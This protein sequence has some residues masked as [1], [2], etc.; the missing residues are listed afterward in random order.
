VVKIRY[1]VAHGNS[2]KIIIYDMYMRVVEEVQ[3]QEKAGITELNI[4]HL[5]KGVYLCELQTSAQRLVQKLVK[6]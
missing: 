6:E 5:P 2:A 4:T 3:V 1:S